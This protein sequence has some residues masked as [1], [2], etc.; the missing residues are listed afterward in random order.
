MFYSNINIFHN[1]I[2]TIKNIFDYI[3]I[4]IAKKQ[5]SKGI[6]T[7]LPIGL[8][9]KEIIEKTIEKYIGKFG[10]KVEASSLITKEL[11]EKSNRLQIFGNELFTIT[12]RNNQTLLLSPTMEEIF[13]NLIPQNISYKKLPIFIYQNTNKYRDEIRVRNSILRSCDFFMHDGYYFATTEKQSMN[14]YKKIENKYKKILKKLNI[15]YIIQDADNEQMMGKKSKEFLSPN[16]IQETKIII[17]NK[18]IKAIEI[19]HI[20]D[21]DIIYSKVLNIKFIDKNSKQKY[22][23]MSSYGLGISR[24]IFILA[25]KIF[26]NQKGILN[27]YFTF[28]PKNHL[29]NELKIIYNKYKKYSIY[30]DTNQHI[31]DMFKI[32]NYIG[33]YYT[34]T[35]HNQIY[36]VYN[37]IN[38]TKEKFQNKDNLIKFINLSIKTIKLNKIIK[39]KNQK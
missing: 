11:Y 32:S 23:Y 17:N 34:I 4:F 30:F 21:L 2:G 13:M 22:I 14:F 37:Q 36:E 26:N 33:V 29:N 10:V 18:Q 15:E 35:Q 12:N 25:Q 38:K 6:F 24:L 1:N 8:M 20:F 5:Q 31:D 19:G 7:F 39:Y 16:D 3:E 27:F 9:L 28:I